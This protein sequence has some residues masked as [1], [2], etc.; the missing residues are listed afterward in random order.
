[1]CLFLEV[2]P[3]S[4]K[5]ILMVASWDKETGRPL[6]TFQTSTRKCYLDW[7]RF[8]FRDPYYERVVQLT[9]LCK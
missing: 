5:N 8:E 6:I 2:L 3:R 1:M 9:L 4:K 7:L